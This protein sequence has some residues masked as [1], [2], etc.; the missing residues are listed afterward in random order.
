MRRLDCLDR[1][2]EILLRAG[3]SLE[4]MYTLIQLRI[5]VH[6]KGLVNRGYVEAQGRVISVGIVPVSI[7]TVTL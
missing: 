3:T 1:A 2:Y 5:Q 7:N 4:L 6:A